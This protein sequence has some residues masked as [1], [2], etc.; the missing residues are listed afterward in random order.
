[1]IK[2]PKFTRVFL[3]VFLI[4]SVFAFK[5]LVYSQLANDV[6]S[7]FFEAFEAVEDA[8]RQGGDVSSLVD[9]LNQILVLMEVGGEEELL[10]VPLRIEA[11]KEG[12]LASG[13]VGE[14]GAQ[15]QLMLSGLILLVTFVFSILVWK[16]MPGLV[17]RFWL[18]SRG[19]WRIYS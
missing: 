3:V 17:W 9:E 10:E 16:F 11:V 7:D 12:A 8:E 19:K 13:R 15:S 14:E 2:S 1:M 18:K 6:Q 5:S 4:T